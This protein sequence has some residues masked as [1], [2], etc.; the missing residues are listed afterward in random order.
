MLAVL[1]KL[2]V[3]LGL[4]CTEASRCPAFRRSALDWKLK[5]FEDEITRNFGSDVTDPSRLSGSNEIGS[6]EGANVQDGAWQERAWNVLGPRK[7][8]VVSFGDSVHEREAN[9]AGC[10]DEL[11]VGVAEVSHSRGT[12]IFMLEVHLQ[13]VVH[14]FQSQTH[15]I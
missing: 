8:N 3:S 7:K 15:T 14:F 1:R 5:A 9:R 13:P 6:R 10:C 12:L 2:R 11:T 4:E